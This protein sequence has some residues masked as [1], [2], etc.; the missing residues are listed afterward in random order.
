LKEDEAGIRNIFPERP[1]FVFSRQI[2]AVIPRKR[3][4]RQVAEHP[5]EKIAI[6]SDQ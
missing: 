6:V 4:R 5:F 2:G 3:R 1:A